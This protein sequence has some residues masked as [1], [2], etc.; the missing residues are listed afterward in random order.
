MSTFGKSYKVC[1]AKNGYT[2]CAIDVYRSDK[3]S[4]YISFKMNNCLLYKDFDRKEK[5]LSLWSGWIEFPEL[6]NMPDEAIIAEFSMWSNAYW[7]T[8]CGPDENKKPYDYEIEYVIKYELHS[9]TQFE[10]RYIRL[11]CLKQFEELSDQ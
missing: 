3:G 7:K 9:L 10:S 1:T 2:R 8:Q 6:I 5:T 4:K 11:S